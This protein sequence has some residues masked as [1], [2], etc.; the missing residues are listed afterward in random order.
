MKRLLII[1]AMIALV[2]CKSHP[3]QAEPMENMV[4]ADMID[5]EWS[6]GPPNQEVALDSYSNLITYAREY[7][8]LRPAIRAAMADDI[9]TYGEYWQIDKDESKL[10][11]TRGAIEAHAGTAPLR[12][13][14]KASLEAKRELVHLHH[15]HDD[16]DLPPHVHTGRLLWALPEPPCCLPD[17]HPV[18]RLFDAPEAPHTVPHGPS[19]NQAAAYGDPAPLP[20]AGRHPFEDWQ[21]VRFDAEGPDTAN[22]F[23]DAIMAIVEAAE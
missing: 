4:A 9:V 5:G 6:G 8:E 16:L 2:A 19:A 7:P 11:L 12:K 1:T 22:E 15:R 23:M 13:Q 17:R 20:V 18:R 14:L 10:A 21:P 3:D